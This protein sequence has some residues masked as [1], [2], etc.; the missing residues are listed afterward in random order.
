VGPAAAASR[1]AMA[2]TSHAGHGQ[3]KRAQ[4]LICAGAQALVGPLARAAWRCEGGRACQRH[5]APARPCLHPAATAALCRT[6]T[7]HMLRAAT[8]AAPSPCH[9][10]LSLLNL[11]QPDAT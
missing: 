8:V 11:M 2:S 3:H 6:T 10:A 4:G 5:L 7:A 1:L 9:Q